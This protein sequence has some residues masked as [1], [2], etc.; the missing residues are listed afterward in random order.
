M[1]PSVCPDCSSVM[2]WKQG[3]YKCKC[4]AV[5]RIKQ[6]IVRKKPERKNQKSKK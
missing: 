3:A 2:E 4:G 6:V 5:K 1:L